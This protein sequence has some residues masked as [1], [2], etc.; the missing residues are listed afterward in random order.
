MSTLPTWKYLQENDYF[1]KHLLYNTFVTHSPDWVNVNDIQDKV[2]VE[3]GGG[4]GRQTVF[5]G[6]FASKVYMIEVSDRIIS[7]AKWYVTKMHKLVN[8]QFILAEDYFTTL[9]GS[10]DYG[11]SY[12]VFQHMTPMQCAEYIN[13]VY[14][15]LKVGGKVSFQFR[16][17]DTQVYGENIEPTVCYTWK[18][19]VRMMKA[20]TMIDTRVKDTH[21]FVYAR[22]DSG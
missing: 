13:V 4:Y 2:V 22:K 15:R 8:V 5:F 10:L 16:L 19:I 12:L 14:D 3:I 9:P 17:G 6:K 7:K 11:Y 1:E 21:I 18:D 20:Y